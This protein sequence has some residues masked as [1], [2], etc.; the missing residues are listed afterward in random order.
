MQVSEPRVSQ[1]H[2]RAVGK[3]RK[4]MMEYYNISQGEEK[5]KKKG[6]SDV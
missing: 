6:V 5:P 4:Q 1:L 2:T 3:L